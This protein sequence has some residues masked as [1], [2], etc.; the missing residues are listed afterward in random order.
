MGQLFILEKKKK[1]KKLE[2]TRQNKPKKGEL[3]EKKSAS[4]ASFIS[5]S[6]R[7]SPCFP[8]K[9]PGIEKALHVTLALRLD[10]GQLCHGRQFRA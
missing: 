2:K 7:K 3:R 4:V 9:E 5:R 10:S 8:T 1:R 6:P